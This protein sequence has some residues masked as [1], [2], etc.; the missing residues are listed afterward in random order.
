ME[1]PFA[2]RH[3][4]SL[5]M[6][7]T[8]H[9]GNSLQDYKIIVKENILQKDMY[10][11]E[12][13]VLSY[14]IKYP[15]FAS[16]LFQSFLND[17]NHMYKEK[18]MNYVNYQIENLFQMAIEEVEHSIA[19]DYPIR[20]YE[21]YTDYVVTYNQNCVISLYFDQYVYTGGAH[22]STERTSDTWDLQSED[23]LELSEI[24]PVPDYKDILIQQIIEQIQHNISEGNNY[25]FEDY[26]SLVREQFN[27]QNFYLSEEGLVLYF[28][29][30][31]IGPYS[32]GILTFTIPYSTDNLKVPGC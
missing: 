25:Y 22:G 9:E 23:E 32:S 17:L 10:Y 24:L 11:E 6:S 1:P 31:E 8:E 16:E 12:E 20:V 30:Y 21:A 14:K 18:A 26:S 15:K 27:V 5:M 7:M 4:L 19:N 29:Q 3:I 13:L 28:Q 2:R